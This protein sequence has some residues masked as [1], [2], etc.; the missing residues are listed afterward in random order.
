[1][2]DRIDPAKLDPTTMGLL[3]IDVQN[4][5]SHPEGTLGK[6]GADI[7]AARAT[8]QPLM[9]VV[10]ACREAGIQDFWSIQQ[11]FENDAGRARHRISNPSAKRPRPSALKGSWDGEVV[12]ELKPYL[13]EKSQIFTKNKF[14][15]FYNTNLETLLRIHGVDTIVV[16][17]LDINVCV[18]TT[19]REAYMRDYDLIILKDCVG[20]VYERWRGPAMEVWDRYLGAVIT[21]DEFLELL[22]AVR[23][24]KV[25]AS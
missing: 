16:A 25:R 11:H 10:T 1:M 15:C 2:H 4:A 17:G 14:G 6:A 20:G 21:S 18:D 22:Q 23:S 13:T 7:S 3:A 24:P 12:E 8:I 19:L 9:R 5:F